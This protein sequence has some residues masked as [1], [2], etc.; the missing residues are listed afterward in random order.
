M[1]TEGRWRLVLAGVL[2]CSALL[3]GSGCAQQSMLTQDSVRQLLAGTNWW[4]HNWVQVG[5]IQNGK[6]VVTPTSDNVQFT[7]HPDG[8]CSYGDQGGESM[9]WRF[10]PPNKIVGTMLGLPPG[11]RTLGGFTLVIHGHELWQLNSGSMEDTMTRSISW[12]IYG[13]GAER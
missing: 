7:F 5:Y 1:H 12:R 8:H 3:L 10:I 6:R 4:G 9:A 11:L 2:A 13:I